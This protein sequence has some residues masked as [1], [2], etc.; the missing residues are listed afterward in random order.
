[1]Y[2]GHRARSSRSPSLNFQCF[3]GV[4]EPGEQALA[5]LVEGDVQH[6]L[7]DRGAGS[8]DTLLERHDLVVAR[9]PDLLGHE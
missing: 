1:M 2:S 8:V 6:A 9:P 5:L 3:D 4:V 7:H